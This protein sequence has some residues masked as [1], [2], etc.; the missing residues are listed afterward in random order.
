MLT[1]MRTTVIID[2]AIF[3]K[4]K[5]AAAESGCTLSDLVNQALSSALAKR[6]EP[7]PEL[8]M[9]VYGGP[10]SVA[11]EPQ[12]FKAGIEADDAESVGR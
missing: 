11:H 9:V 3:R 4:A 12:D 8:Q 7:R 2:D 1:S 6:R 5:R 10:P